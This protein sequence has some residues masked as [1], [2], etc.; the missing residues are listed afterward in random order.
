MQE[1]IDHAKRTDQRVIV[2]QGLIPHTGYRFRVRA[3]NLY[4][5]GEEA[6]QPSGNILFIH[7]RVR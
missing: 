3:I 5:R 6:S 4:G 1:A 2:V 7:H